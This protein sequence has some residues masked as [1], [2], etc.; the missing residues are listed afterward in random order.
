MS[1]TMKTWH[2]DIKL[3]NGQVASIDAYT[4][5]EAFAIL[6]RDNRFI[7][8]NWSLVDVEDKLPEFDPT[9][10]E[11]KKQSEELWAK[12]DWNKLDEAQK[13][14]EAGYKAFKT[15]MEFDEKHLDVL[16]YRTSYDMSKYEL[17]AAEKCVQYARQWIDA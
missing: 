2:F 14:L 8:G 3:G 17:K 13:A 10:E 12:I 6:K 5:E 15:A 7:E 4:F 16:G 11:I 1:K 9:A